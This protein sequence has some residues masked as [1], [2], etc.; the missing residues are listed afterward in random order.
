M[1]V[2]AILPLDHTAEWR[3]FGMESLRVALHQFCGNDG[4]D[5]M[6]EQCRL[7]T[8]WQSVSLVLCVC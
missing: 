3:F 8:H 6:L 5:T 2:C 7:A 4:G 1:I